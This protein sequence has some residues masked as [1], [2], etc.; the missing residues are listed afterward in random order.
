[1][2]SKFIGEINKIIDITLIVL[3]LNFICGIL[4]EN[5]LNCFYFRF[6]TNSFN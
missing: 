6:T 5:S 4:I 3:V 1:M 2:V